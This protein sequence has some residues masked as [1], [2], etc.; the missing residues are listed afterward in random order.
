MGK[1]RIAKWVGGIL[2]LA[3]FVALLMPAIS[4]AD[5]VAPGWTRFDDTLP[6]FV[7]SAGVPTWDTAVNAGSFSGAARQTLGADPGMPSVSFTF[8]ASGVKW[9]AR[10]GATRGIAKV[11]LDGVDQPLVDLYAPAPGGF[12]VPVFVSG[13]LNPSVIHTMKITMTDTRGLGS[14][15]SITFDAVDL[16]TGGTL[17]PTPIVST[18]ASSPS[19]LAILAGLG[20]GLISLGV[21]ARRRASA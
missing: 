11:T 20:I 10:T 21:V 8:R 14:N 9:I 5:P 6:D 18:S 17:S 4:S 19:S 15:N 13:A 2:A 3:A 16:P 12:Q 1:R 7:Y